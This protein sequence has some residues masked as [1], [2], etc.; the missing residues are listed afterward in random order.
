MT[1][2][3]YILSQYHLFYRFFELLGK[4]DYENIR[5]E[6]GYDINSGKPIA[7]WLLENKYDFDVDKYLD[8]LI[9]QIGKVVMKDKKL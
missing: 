5:K 1:N 9:N 6:Y 2:L 4:G 7:D 3:D 8:N